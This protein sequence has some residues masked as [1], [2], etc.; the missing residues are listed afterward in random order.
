[1][2]EDDSTQPQQAIEHCVGCFTYRLCEQWKE[3]WYCVQRCWSKR[4]LIH[5]DRKKG[6]S[7]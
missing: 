3:E 5:T 7:R 6:E 1:M 4:Q 2:P